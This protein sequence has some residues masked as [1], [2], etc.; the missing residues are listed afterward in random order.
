MRLV[1]G[2]G[3]VVAELFNDLRNLFL[4][5]SENGISNDFL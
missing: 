4:F 5:S 2:V 3:I 1:H